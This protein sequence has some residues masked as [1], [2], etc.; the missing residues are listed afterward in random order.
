MARLTTPVVSRA[1]GTSPDGGADPVSD[2]DGASPADA[3]G[4]GQ[5]K[6]EFSRRIFPDFFWNFPD[7]KFAFFPT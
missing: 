5:G 2:A 6:P 1:L 3:D 4:Y 7:T